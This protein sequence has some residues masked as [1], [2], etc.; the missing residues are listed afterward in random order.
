MW[1][2]IEKA[3]RVHAERARRLDV[4]PRDVGLGAV[5][6]DAH[7]ARAG[8]IGVLEIVNGS[9]ARQQQHGH[10]GALALLRDRGDP[11][12]VVV[13]AEAVVEGRAGDAVAVAD[14][15]RVDA[16]AVERAGDLAHRLQVILVTDRMHAVTQRDVLDIE[17]VLVLSGHHAASFCS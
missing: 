14:L 1:A 13:G 2:I 8:V 9:D 15:D 5:G 6:G 10:D 12:A 11:L 7:A 4:L 16:R 17:L 3:D